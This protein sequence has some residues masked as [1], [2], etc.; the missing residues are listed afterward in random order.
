[1]RVQMVHMHPISTSYQEEINPNYL[2]SNS[3]LTSQELSII[4]H[5]P[6]HTIDS[7][8]DALSSSPLKEDKSSPQDDHRI[9]NISLDRQS[10][11]SE[12]ND[13]HDVKEMIATVT[14]LHS[15]YDFL[16]QQLQA[17]VA[18]VSS[19]MPTGRSLVGSTTSVASVSSSVSSI[20]VCSTSTST[21][22]SSP[23]SF[24]NLTK[25]PSTTVSTSLSLKGNTILSNSSQLTASSMNGV[26]STPT[27]STSPSS[28]VPAEKP[29]F[30]YVALITLAINNSEN[31]RATL[32]QIY[33]YISTNYPYYQK[34]K[35]G[36]QNSIRHNL[37]LNA[38]FQKIPR[39]GAGEKKGNYWALD[40]LCGN[41][42]EN[43]NFR[44]RRR[45]KR[46]YRHSLLPYP[47]AKTPFFGT[48]SRDAYHHHITAVRDL[49]PP[50]THSYPNYSHGSA[51]TNSQLSYPHYGSTSLSQFPST[52]YSPI[53]QL[54]SQL[55]PIQ[56]MQLSSMNG[57][58]SQSSNLNGNTPV[59]DQFTTH[60]NY[61][62][63]RRHEPT[64]Y[65]SD[66]YSSYWTSPSCDLNTPF[67]EEESLLENG[68]FSPNYSTADS[69]TMSFYRPQLLISTGTRNE[70]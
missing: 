48:G 33:D 67:K 22:N 34:N 51:W 23:L 18:S 46:P 54:Q 25:C 35:K 64:A 1:M 55:S 60:N 5:L 52:M 50:S 15:P 28:T 68:D 59:L 43:G 65:L 58:N 61:D 70:L 14:N 40:P 20:D 39:E 69:Y 47:L 7:A 49:Y 45:M 11:C 26:S 13:N 31:K 8:D 2:I 17:A 10:I 57:Y 62:S 66:K 36:W 9:D 37:S 63:T 27:P 53:P 29:P 42:F 24:T 21:L 6:E 16:A 4:S 56:T 30:S 3:D 44:R 41:M 38:C 32:S 12:Y 19:T